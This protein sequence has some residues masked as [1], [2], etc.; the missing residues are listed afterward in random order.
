[1]AN[2][3]DIFVMIIARRKVK[4]RKSSFGSCFSS[5]DDFDA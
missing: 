2:V 4:T 5:A 1:M 3:N